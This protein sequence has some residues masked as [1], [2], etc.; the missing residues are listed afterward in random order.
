[1]VY[2]IKTRVA[3]V[4][5]LGFGI[6]RVTGLFIAFAAVLT[7]AWTACL[8]AVIWWAVSVLFGP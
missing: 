5:N 8:A 7:A 3:Q 2:L 6:R 4:G 1:M